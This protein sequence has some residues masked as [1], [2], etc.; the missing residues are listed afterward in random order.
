M[1]ARALHS[2]ETRDVMCTIAED[3]EQRVPCLGHSDHLTLL[4]FLIAL[5]S[6]ILVAGIFLFIFLRL[7]QRV[8]LTHQNVPNGIN[9]RRSQYVRLRIEIRK[10]QTNIRQYNPRPNGSQLAKERR[11]ILDPTRLPSSI[12][13]VPIRIQPS[14]FT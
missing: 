4:F 8:I 3:V 10:Q 6:S 1:S 7:N 9:N 11:H 12:I 13:G 14:D 5:F 2:R